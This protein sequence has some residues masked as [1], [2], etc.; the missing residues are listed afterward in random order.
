[1]E[2]S[3]DQIVQEFDNLVKGKGHQNREIA[4]T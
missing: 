1:M 4:T 2:T 3:N